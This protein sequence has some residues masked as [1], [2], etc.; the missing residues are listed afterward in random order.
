MFRWAL[1]IFAF[2]LSAVFMLRAA[3]GITSRSEDKRASSFILPTMLLAQAA[4]A[5]VM[6]VV[7]FKFVVLHHPGGGEGAPHEDPD[8]PEPPPAPPSPTP[9]N[10]TGGN[11]T[12]L[13]A[14]F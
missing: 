4:L 1:V 6:K 7:F 8:V 12:F 13:A 11:D 10:G 14:Y 3:H 9:G 2:V 5:L